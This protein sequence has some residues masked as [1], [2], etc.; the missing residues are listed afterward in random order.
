MNVHDALKKRRS[1]RE[2][3]DKPVE[4]SLLYE[5]IQSALNAPSWCN[6]QPYQF[7]VL[8]GNKKDTLAQRL[9]AKFDAAMQLKRASLLQRARLLLTSKILPDGDF[10]V[11]FNNYPDIFK[12]RRSQC[13]HG[14]YSTLGIDRSDHTARDQQA[15][16]NFEFFQAPVVILFFVHHSSREYGVL[17]TG[18]FL[19]SLMLLA[20]EKGLGSCAQ[21]A[22]ATWRSP[23]NELVNIPRG[24]KLLCGMSL[25]Y[26]KDCAVNQFNP[27]RPQI[28]EFM[29]K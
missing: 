24:Y 11:Q 16:K 14:L 25:G 12:K 20:Q 13:G 15:R 22:L 3:E 27:G 4:D 9:T 29:I 6:V 17:D 8:K 2:Y 1:I 28:D 7:A 10:N 5:I 18:A 26:A 23:V 21:G 19:Q